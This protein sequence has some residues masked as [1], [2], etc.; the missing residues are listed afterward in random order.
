MTT[1]SGDSSDAAFYG[2]SYQREYGQLAF[3]LR[4]LWS[5]VYYS[6]FRYTPPGCFAW[7][8]LILQCFRARLAPGSLVYPSARIWAPW[9]LQMARGACLGPEVY[10]YNVAPV[11]IGQ[12]VT[13]SFRTFL[14]SASHD[15]D[16]IDRTLTSG[17]ITI[18]R[19]AYIFADAFIGMNVTISEGAVVGAR[20]V[21]VRDV[22]PFMVVAGNPARE[23]RERRLK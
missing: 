1:D 15:I 14:C 2:S 16:S 18:E 21:V 7:R 23:I 17:P 12:D 11:S 19:G 20:A 22:R 13:V 5:V 4:L 10:C 9:N 6:A 8:R 3:L